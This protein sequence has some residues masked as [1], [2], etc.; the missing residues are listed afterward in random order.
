MDPELSFGRGNHYGVGNVRRPIAEQ[1]KCLAKVLE[2]VKL[3]WYLDGAL[4]EQSPAPNLV[5]QGNTYQGSSHL[6]PTPAVSCLQACDQ[7]NKVHAES[8]DKVACL[9]QAGL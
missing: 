8:R 2:G 7:D 5:Y 1:Q 9:Y 6:H 4:N 3:G